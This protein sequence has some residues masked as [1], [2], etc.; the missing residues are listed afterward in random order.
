MIKMTV[1]SQAEAK[2]S[3][4]NILRSMIGALIKYKHTIMA[5]TIAYMHTNVTFMLPFTVINLF[6]NNQPDALIV[7][8]CLFSCRYNPLWLYF[9]SPVAGVILLILEVS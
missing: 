6:L 1:L 7:C 9:H 5:L 8:C 2:G 4:R 3:T